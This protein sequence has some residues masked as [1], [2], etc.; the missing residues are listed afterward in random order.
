MLV[1]TIM[2]D[3][4]DKVYIDALVVFRTRGVE[5]CIIEHTVSKDG[6]QLDLLCI[7]PH[8]V[9]ILVIDLQGLR[10]IAGNEMSIHVDRRRPE[11]LKL[12]LID[13][14]DQFLFALC[15]LLELFPS[16]LFK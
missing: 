6:F 8:G 13:H 4:V 5:T 10:M 1:T 9:T 2:F 3:G 12:G 7:L 15:M 11:G 16:W 14:P